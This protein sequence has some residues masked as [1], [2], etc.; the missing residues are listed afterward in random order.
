MRKLKFGMYVHPEIS[1]ETIRLFV[2]RLD[3]EEERLK[4]E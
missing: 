4:T 2:R 3:L 1:E